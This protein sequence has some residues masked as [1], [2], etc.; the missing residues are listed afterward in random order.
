LLGPLR[1]I[2]LGADR[3]EWEN[4]I[5]LFF[6]LLISALISVA[7]VKANS[8]SVSDQ[9]SAICLDAT[10]KN[11]ANPETRDA[12]RDGSF[13]Y[14]IEETRKAALSSFDHIMKTLENTAKAAPEISSR[15][16]EYT[17]E[18]VESYKAAPQLSALDQGLAKL[19]CP[20]FDTSCR[21]AVSDVLNTAS[22]NKN[23]ISLPNELEKIFA[24]PRFWKA[25]AILA[26]QI[27]KKISQA[28]KGQTQLGN[29]FD[30]TVSAFVSSGDTLAQAKEDALIILGIYGSRGNTIGEIL[31]YL[32]PPPDEGNGILI[33]SSPG[34]SLNAVFSSLNYL[35]A[36]TWK[37]GHPYS[38]PP[39]L[40][41]S[42]NYTRP[43]HFWFSAYLAYRS[44]HNCHPATAAFRA[45]HLLGLEYELLGTWGTFGKSEFHNQGD[46]YRIETLKNVAY[47]DMG[48]FFGASLGK[49]HLPTI[50]GDDLIY[51]MLDRSRSARLN[52]FKDDFSSGQSL[53]FPNYFLE[54]LGAEANT[55]NLIKELEKSDQ[56][57]IASCPEQS[58]RGCN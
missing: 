51:E 48:A 39:Q 54:K 26:L 31:Q 58:M 50:S 30:D 45:V 37:T 18:K 28:E 4:K 23:N 9:V 1:A 24:E 36:V 43:Y 10:Q 32:S 55:P 12:S 17:H 57:P 5:V 25:T 33:Y 47:N 3:R 13:G 44:V 20:I 52:A 11:L 56:T 7:P 49:A 42:C 29:V 21:S 40:T 8:P 38:Y 6:L 14:D 22:T 35:D 53:V 19:A 16:K 15:M 2:L 34:S 27:R 46:F 41:T